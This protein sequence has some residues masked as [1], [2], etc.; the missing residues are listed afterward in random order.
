M[1]GSRARVRWL[2]PPRCRGYAV[3]ASTPPRR[4]GSARRAHMRPSGLGRATPNWRR[5]SREISHVPASSRW[6]NEMSPPPCSDRR[7]LSSATSCRHTKDAVHKKVEINYTCSID[8]NTVL[9][10]GLPAIS[11][12]STVRDSWCRQLR[13]RVRKSDHTLR[14]YRRSIEAFLRFCDDTGVPRELTK[15][16]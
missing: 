5:A 13:V 2:P 11:R 10:S 1:R 6:L 16:T 12:I 7:C 15:R 14:S 3:G 9:T 8:H 4:R